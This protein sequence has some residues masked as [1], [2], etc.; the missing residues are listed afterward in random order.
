MTSP[1]YARPSG[2]RT[3]FRARRIV[4]RSVLGAAV[5]VT[6]QA[7]AARARGD[8]VTRLLADLERARSYKVR[9]GA[10]VT[11]ART[12]DARVVP[13]LGRAAQRDIE[14]IVR[15]TAVRLLASNPGGDP[16]GHEARRA[17]NAAAADRAPEVRRA[18]VEA[19][20]ALDA[21]VAHAA[22]ARREF[23]IAIRSVGDRTGR[24][25]RAVRDRMKTELVTVLR[26][27]R[28]VRVADQ[29]APGEG[30]VVDGTVAK[31]D[32]AQGKLDVE[33]TCGIELVVSRPPRGIVLVATGEAT[34]QRPRIYFRPDQRG[35][36][37]EEAVR[38][39]V[40]SA[41]ENLARFLASQ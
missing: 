6:V 37:E 30:F 31:L 17:L 7:L 13:A 14:P 1:S 20:A 28:D 5:L 22:R 21:S 15:L 8:T 19:L 35:G 39:A 33:T 25:S 9:V 29:V 23:A 26:G 4:R 18:A 24:A 40:R 32:H 36:M 38:H 16:T 27:S 11:L 2:L 12:G 3:P 34:V 41:H 10:A